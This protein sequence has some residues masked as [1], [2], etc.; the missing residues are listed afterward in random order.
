MCISNEINNE[1]NIVSE[2][3]INAS[4]IGNNNNNSINV[5]VQNNSNGFSRNEIH[6]IEVLERILSCVLKDLMNVWKLC[7]FVIE[8]INVIN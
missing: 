3:S 1:G 5:Y 4:T 6:D 8:N 2:S 7:Y